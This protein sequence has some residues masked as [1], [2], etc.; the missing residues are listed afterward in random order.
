MA[1]QEGGYSNPAMEPDSETVAET[2]LTNDELCL[3]VDK[4][5]VIV[6]SPVLHFYISAMG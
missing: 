1:Q 6:D 3:R 2:S 5:E 4:L